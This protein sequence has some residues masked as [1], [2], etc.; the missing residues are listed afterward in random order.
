MLRCRFYF[1]TSRF[2]LDFLHPRVRDIVT[3]SFKGRPSSH[4]L[5]I[6]SLQSAELSTLILIEH[7]IHEQE[8]IIVLPQIILYHHYKITKVT[9]SISEDLDGIS[10]LLVFLHHLNGLLSHQ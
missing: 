7:C 3:I 2:Y 1:L 4:T 10:L 8:E 5:L 9:P 6:C